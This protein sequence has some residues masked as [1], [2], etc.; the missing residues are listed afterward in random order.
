MASTSRMPPRKRL[1]RPSPCDDAPLQ[2][3]DVDE[4][5]GGVHDL[6]RLAH[7][8]QRVEALVGDLWRRRRW[9]RWS[10]TDAA[11][12]AAEPPVSA[13]N[14]ADFP[15]LGSPTSP[16]RSIAVEGSVRLGTFRRWTRSRRST[17]SCTCS[18]VTWRP[19]RKAKAF[20]RA[21]RPSAATDPDELRKLHDRGPAQG[22]AGHRREHRPR[23]RRGA[24]RQGARLPREARGD[25]EIPIGEGGDDP[26]RAQGR[27]PHPLRV[28]RRRRAD[29]GDGA[30]RAGARPRLHRAD[31]PLRRASPSRTG[32]SAERLRGPARRGRPRSTSSWRPSA[33]SPGWRST[34]SRTARLDM[35]DD[36]LGRARRRRRQRALEAAHGTRRR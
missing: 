24:R 4:L 14:S 34:S 16:N 18:T 7:L 28:V 20:L 3:G 17:A 36:M 19:R 11:A 15:A 12:T 21:A 13:L 33:S 30:R 6:L 25:H 9:S 23:H 32:S 2:P 1:P 26:R 5:R 29:R 10:R 35:T 22:A 27:L 8:R 31:R